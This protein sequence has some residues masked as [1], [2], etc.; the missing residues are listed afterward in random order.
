MASWLRSPASRFWRLPCDGRYES[1]DA[2]NPPRNAAATQSVTQPGARAGKQSPDRLPGRGSRVGD[3][4]R[5]EPVRSQQHSRGNERVCPRDHLSGKRVAPSRTISYFATPAQR[6]SHPGNRMFPVASA[7]NCLPL[8]DLA[9]S[10]L[11]ER[12]NGYGPGWG[13]ASALAKGQ[14]TLARFGRRAG[15]GRN[16]DGNSADLRKSPLPGTEDGIS[17]VVL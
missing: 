6:R 4:Q 11:L 17:L 13:M 12:S 15:P 10:A 7:K 8:C 14:I 2:T 3:A 1:S 9:C 5:L 16:R